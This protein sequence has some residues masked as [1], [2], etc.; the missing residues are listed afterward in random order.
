MKMI[1]ECDKNKEKFFEETPKNLKEISRTLHECFVNYTYGK[2]LF[3]MGLA[4]MKAVWAT[5]TAYVVNVWNDL[6]N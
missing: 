4:K 6:L 2:E 1:F 3:V 5:N